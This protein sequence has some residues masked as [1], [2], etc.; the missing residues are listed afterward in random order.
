MRTRD[1]EEERVHTVLLEYGQQHLY[2]M[3]LLQKKGK[4]DRT[5]IKVL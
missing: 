2:T 5:G 1:Q 3:A 4:P